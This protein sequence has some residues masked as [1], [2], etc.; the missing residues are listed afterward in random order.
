[1]T[2]YVTGM[3]LTAF[4][5]AQVETATLSAPER[6][7]MPEPVLAES[8]TDLDGTE[9]GEVEVDA[10]SGAGSNTSWLEAVEAE[11]RALRFLG[12]AMEVGGGGGPG[13]E[14][15]RFAGGG[16]ALSALHDEVHDAHLSIE[17]I[18]RI[19]PSSAS[20]PDVDQTSR[21]VATLVHGGIR[22]GWLTVRATLGA[23]S[24]LDRR[25]VIGPVGAAS[26]FLAPTR[27][28]FAG[29]EALASTEEPWGIIA[30]N[31]AFQV[32]PAV[33]LGL[34]LPFRPVATVEEP[35]LA[36]ILRTVVEFD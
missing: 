14:A 20:S 25:E 29:V 26:V 12:L 6:P 34:A 11:W 4:V 15:Q 28:W 10:L 3:S 32:V 2:V 8:I 22:H 1:V 31:V 5:V 7:K 19:G 30:P 21:P 18:G 9:A 27:Y 13:A 23:E 17:V 33:Q 16:I 36:A 35:R 24:T